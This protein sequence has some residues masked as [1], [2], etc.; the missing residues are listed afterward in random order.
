MGSL[1][2]YINSRAFGYHDLPSFPEIP[3]DPSV[4]NIATTDVSPKVVKKQVT[5]NKKKSFYSDSDNSSPNEGYRLCFYFEFYISVLILYSSLIFKLCC[6]LC[7]QIQTIV[8]KIVKINQVMRNLANMQMRKAMHLKNH[9]ILRK[10]YFC[11]RSNI[12]YSEYV[13]RMIIN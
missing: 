10:R 1:S 6:F 13:L 11:L 8:I 3:P 9:V 12:N 7:L 4:R 5:S 2:H